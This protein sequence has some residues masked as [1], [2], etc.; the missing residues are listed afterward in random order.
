VIARGNAICSSAL[1]AI[2]AVPPPSGGSAAAL[3]AYLQKVRP[4]VDKET[5]QLGALP[6]PAAR[7]AT[8][9]AFVAAFEA[10]DRAYR[11]A[12]AAGG[13]GDAD[14]I[15]QALSALRSSRVAPLA[16]AYGLTDCTGGLATV[17]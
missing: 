10:S 6:R 15:A 14:G 16:R 4:I 2:R 9:D 1:S 5:S 13:R 3:G 8:L 7:K 12:A 11:R 17:S